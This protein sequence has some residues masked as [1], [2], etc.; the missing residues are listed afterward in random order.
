M[1][2][3]GLDGLDGHPRFPQPGEAGV[4][5]LV[6]GAVAE[7]GPLAGRPHDLVES[8]CGKRLTPTLPFERDEQRV[9]RGLRWPFVVHVAG[10]SGKEGGRKWHQA[11]VASL[12]LGD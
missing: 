5:K 9:G 11:F 3:L 2:G 7:T 6:T 1:T 4:A 8:W 12:A 10:D